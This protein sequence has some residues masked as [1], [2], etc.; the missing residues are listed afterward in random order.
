MSINNTR[1]E[2][3]FKLDT[4]ITMAVWKV[5]GLATLCRCYAEVGG[6]NAKL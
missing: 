1:N 5:R 4:A 3:K 6:D 2:C